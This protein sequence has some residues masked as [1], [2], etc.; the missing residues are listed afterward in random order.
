MDLCLS[1]GAF[2]VFCSF[3]SW[4]KQTGVPTAGAESKGHKTMKSISM[5]VLW[6]HYHFNHYCLFS[7]AFFKKCSSCYILSFHLYFK[8]SFND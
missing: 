4:L 1:P 2:R 8:L 7:H 5:G 3:H 6:K